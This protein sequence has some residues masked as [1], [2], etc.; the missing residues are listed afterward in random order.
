[1]K[2]YNKQGT[3]IQTLDTS[4]E[5]AR[6]G[7]G[8]VIDH[9]TEVA[10][11]YLPGIKPITE[12]KFVELQE[13]SS[14]I[15]IKPK[16]LA[17]DQ[18]GKIIGY[19]MNKVP[20]DHFPILSMFNKTFCI[21]ENVSDKTK[22]NIIERLIDA[23]NFAHS[24]GVIIG[25][26]N[27]YNILVNTQGSVF[28]ID[29]D[30]YG[31][32]SIKHSGILFDEIRDYLYGGVVNCDSDY[33]SLS[34]I[35]F[36]MLTYVHP[37]KG[38][39]KQVPKMSE[40]ML[41]KLPIFKVDPNLSTPKCYLPI[42]NPFLQEQFVDFYEIGKRFIINPKTISIIQTP[43]KATT[44]VAQQLNMHEIITGVSI[45]RT[46][47]TLTT[48][49]VTLEDETLIYSVGNK[50]AWF[51]KGSFPTKPT[52]KVFLS[53]TSVYV[54]R[55]KILYALNS[56]Y[57]LSIIKDF[58][59]EN[60]LKVK[61]FDNI[62]LVVTDTMKYEFHLATVFHGVVKVTTSNV[63]GGKFVN[64]NSLF[65]KVDNS[66]VLFYNKNQVINSVVLNKVIKDAYQVDDVGIIRYLEQD[67]LIHKYFKITNLQIELFDCDLDD[68]RRCSKL[69]PD[70]LI[71]P[72][73]DE[74]ELIHTANMATIAKY[75]CSAV[76][77]DS[78]IHC[79]G[80]GI[81]I[82]NPSGIYLAN[83]K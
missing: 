24:K 83:K 21:R 58:T 41:K 10:K 19:F 66:T 2:V 54:L 53:D 44:I 71:V 52:D 79:C 6:G 18:Y 39:H 72:Q 64:I 20:A 65:M 45:I 43:K 7:E 62:L 31:T 57:D 63:F 77:T 11:I 50:G 35:V 1:M 12:V 3:V 68:L 47:C 4:K 38:I 36:N 82:I 33:F 48:L 70:L 16:S 74:L 5:L 23:M 8:M 32:K 37:F 17:Y 73:D 27:P 67:K 81:I 26:F 51:L 78:V 29:V 42:T 22:I 76:S 40:R 9:G 60:H 15:F 30:S 34:V 56:S 80:A 59:S 13:L 69:T 14:N 46:A 49:A 55:D 75:Q 25:D 28:L 61:Y